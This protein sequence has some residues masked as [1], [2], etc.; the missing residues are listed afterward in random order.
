M[1]FCP[2]RNCN[3]SMTI[4]KISSHNAMCNNL[5]LN[6][7]DDLTS[8]HHFTITSF[9]KSYSW[10][11]L[12]PYFIDIN[13]VQSSVISHF[14]LKSDFSDTYLPI[15]LNI[16]RVEHLENESQR[17]VTFV[18]YMTADCHPELST[19]FRLNWEVS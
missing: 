15:Y 13:K 7:K 11:T 12:H 8:I 5:L 18:F 14:L 6:K 16:L 4:D 9:S 19:K 1:F 17:I 2:R 10:R 3:V